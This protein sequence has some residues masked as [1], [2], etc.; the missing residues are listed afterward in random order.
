MAL[1]NIF[2]H[3]YSKIFMQIAQLSY[4]EWNVVC[5]LY[6]KAWTDVAKAPSRTFYKKNL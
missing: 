5:L 4:L 1:L 3:T 6:L 2:L